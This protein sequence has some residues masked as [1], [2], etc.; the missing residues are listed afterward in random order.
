[1]G[2]FFG[3]FGS[4]FPVTLTT[5]VQGLLRECGKPFEVV[6]GLYLRARVSTAALCL[7]AFNKTKGYG[8]ALH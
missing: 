1:M 8:I 6:C 7:F 5:R 4:S 3:V 2:S